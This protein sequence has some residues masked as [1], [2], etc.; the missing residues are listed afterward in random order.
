MGRQAG[1]FGLV[2]YSPKRQEN[3]RWTLGLNYNLIQLDGRFPGEFGGMAAV[4][5]G[6]QHGVPGYFQL[7]PAVGAF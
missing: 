3:I 4:L 1:Y 7:G 6:R 2:G 5:A